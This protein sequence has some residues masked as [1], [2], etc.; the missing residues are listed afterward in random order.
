MGKKETFRVCAHRDIHQLIGDTQGPVK[1]ANQFLEALKTRGL[2][3][4][5]IRAY[6]FDLLC[7]YRWMGKKGHR[8]EKLTQSTLLDFVCAQQ[9]VGAHPNSINRRLVVCGLLYRFWINKEVVQGIGASVPA[10]YYKGPGR[11]RNLGLHKIRKSGT[12]A[13]RVKV[14][15]KIIE[16]LTAK[17]VQIFL[18]RLRRYRDLAI[19]YLML[20]CGLRSREVLDIKLT[21]IFFDENRLRV[22]GKGGK[23]RALPIP[24][25]VLQLV[26]EYLRWERPSH[27]NSA[28]LFV[29][30]QGKNRGRPMTPDGLRSLFRW[31]RLDA[32]IAKANPHRFRH[33]FGADMARSGVRLPILQVMMGHAD[34]KMTLQ[35]INLSMADIADE[36]Q[37]AMKEIQKR[38]QDT[39]PIG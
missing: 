25:I 20:L 8:L 36:Y 2:S 9:D 37:R 27:I 4:R 33:T 21:D 34:A 10:S 16:P 29:V 5:T 14:P 22:R 3:P 18:R 24:E 30:L 12:R 39:N 35:Y 31:R 28:T 7:L 1:E 26:T 32:S 11:D 6:A 15:H 17:Q 13:L 23:E 38:Y 19:V